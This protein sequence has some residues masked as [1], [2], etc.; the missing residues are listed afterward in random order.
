[1]LLCSLS[2]RPFLENA[3]QIL[4]NRQYSSSLTAAWPVCMCVHGTAAAASTVRVCVFAT[5]R[6]THRHHEVLRSAPDPGIT[7][8][9]F[10]F[11]RAR[12]RP[13]LP[14]YGDEEKAWQAG[15]H[16]G[17]PHDTKSFEQQA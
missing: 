8:L 7:V 2:V 13:A 9:V 12:A 11:A 10:I 1:M 17:R 15:C 16:T 5:A 4:V 6:W 3:G 14:L